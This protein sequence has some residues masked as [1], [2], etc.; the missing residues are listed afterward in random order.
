MQTEG[1][2]VPL[3]IAARSD[4]RTNW[5]GMRR[6]KKFYAW[7]YADEG[8]TPVLVGNPIRLASKGESGDAHAR[9]S[10]Y[11]YCCGLY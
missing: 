7:G 4:G 6:Q 5:R 9:W 1:I 8:L 10:T 11:S 3:V 2:A